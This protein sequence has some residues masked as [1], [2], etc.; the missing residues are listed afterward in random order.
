MFSGFITHQKLSEAPRE[1]EALY[2]A[3]LIA[4][5]LVEAG[6][7]VPQIYRPMDDIFAVR[8]I[9]AVM[10]DEVKAV[11]EAVGAAFS[12]VGPEFLRISKAPAA[13]H[14]LLLGEIV[15]GL[16][17]QSYIVAAWRTHVAPMSTKRVTPFPSITRSSG[18]SPSTVTVIPP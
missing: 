4:G 10:D 13:M 2:D 5:R 16:F 1:L 15:L 18:A 17:I 11:T 12:H 9:P 3:W 8:W 7:V 6:A 14:P